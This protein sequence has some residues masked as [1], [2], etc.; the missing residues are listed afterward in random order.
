VL[1]GVGATAAGWWGGRWAATILVFFAAS[2]GVQ[3][4]LPPR[5]RRVSRLP[6]P[7]PTAAALTLAYAAY[8]LTPGSVWWL[9]LAVGAGPAIHYLGD[10]LTDS[11]CPLLWP[12]PLGERGRRRRWYPVGPP[13]ILRF[14]AGGRVE[15]WLVQPAL[16][17]LLVAAVLVVVWPAVAPVW[18]EIVERWTAA[19]ITRGA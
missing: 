2:V 12:L 8:Q 17:V 18:A 16:T 6:I 11:A 19:R 5:W 3:A 1:C 15:R 13:K 14:N 4:I 10:M 7:V 9:G